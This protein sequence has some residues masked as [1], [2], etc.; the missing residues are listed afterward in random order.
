VDAIVQKLGREAVANPS[1]V[2]ALWKYIKALERIREP[3]NKQL[4]AVLHN[5]EADHNWPHPTP[6]SYQEGDGKVEILA[7]YL[8][9]YGDTLDS[10]YCSYFYENIKG[11]WI[12]TQDVV[13][14]ARH[15]H[16]PWID[17]GESGANAISSAEKAFFES[18]AIEK[19]SFSLEDWETKPSDD[20]EWYPSDKLQEKFYTIWDA[21]RQKEDK[22]LRRLSSLTQEERKQLGKTKYRVKYLPNNTLGWVHFEYKK[23]WTSDALAWRPCTEFDGG[24][25]G[26]NEDK[27]VLL[28]EAKVISDSAMP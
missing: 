11:A 3:G 17:Y 26:W 16:N 27:V 8:N 20:G 5:G 21:L 4:Y 7:N 9:W 22:G 12:V 19:L 25:K 24:G 1:D 23:R 15:A 14:Y 28:E 2:D 18:L 13:D 10:E 6:L